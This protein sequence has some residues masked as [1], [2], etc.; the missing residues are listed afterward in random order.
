MKKFDVRCHGPLV[1][2]VVLTLLMILFIWGNSCLSQEVSSAN[3]GWITEMLQ[4]IIDP[5]GKIPVEEF[6]HFVRKVAHFMEFA[7]LGL[8]VGTMF[9]MIRLRA[10]GRLCALP[11]LII[12]LAAVLDEYIQFFAHRGSAVP[13]VI[14]DFCGGLFG[15]GI[16]LLVPYLPKKK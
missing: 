16:A 11:V 2:L 5:G 8:L 12:L 10:G 9:Q 1:L 14:L 4:S 6:H 13:D 3:S 15:L 7:L